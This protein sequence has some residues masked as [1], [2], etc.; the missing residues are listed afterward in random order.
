MK[1]QC[2]RN[3]GTLGYIK[4]NKRKLEGNERKM[5]RQMK[6]NERKMTGTDRTLT[7]KWKEIKGNSIEHERTWRT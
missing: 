3:E 6:R 1:G 5:K 7:N 2:K 4:E